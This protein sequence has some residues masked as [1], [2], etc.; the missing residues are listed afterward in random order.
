MGDPQSGKFIEEIPLELVIWGYP[1]FRKP[2]YNIIEPIY[3]PKV[4]SL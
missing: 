2:P 3:I 1:Y 4:Y